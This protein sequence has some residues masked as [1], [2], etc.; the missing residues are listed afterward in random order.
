VSSDKAAYLPYHP[1]PEINAEIAVEALA[2]EVADLAAGYAPRAWIC[3]CGA[4]HSRGHFLT[5]GQHRCLSCGYVG[6]DGVM[7]T[8]GAADRP[9]RC[10]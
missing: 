9:V 10:G 6:T 4:S 1:D 7:R 5:I 3:P 2:A 8:L